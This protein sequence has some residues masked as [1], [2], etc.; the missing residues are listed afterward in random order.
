MRATAQ[1]I[2]HNGLVRN[3]ADSNCNQ[4]ASSLHCTVYA[5]DMNEGYE[6]VHEIASEKCK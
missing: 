2:R 5:L 1:L 3:D 4:R 6:Q